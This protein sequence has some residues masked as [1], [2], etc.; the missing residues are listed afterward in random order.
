V[1]W[2]RVAA[3]SAAVAGDRPADRVPGGRRCGPVRTAGRCA[4]GARRPSITGHVAGGS[5]PAALLVSRTLQGSSV[6]PRCAAGTAHRGLVF[7]QRRHA[8]SSAGT[9]SSQPSSS[10]AAPA[11]P[12]R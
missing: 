3:Q 5:R 10:P 8:T 11:A 4:E 2:G 1:P 6:A 7:V 9:M 12:R